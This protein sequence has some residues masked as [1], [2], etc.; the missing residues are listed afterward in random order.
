MSQTTTIRCSRL[1]Y[2]LAFLYKCCIS[3]LVIVNSCVG[4]LDVFSRN[5]LECRFLSNKHSMRLRSMRLRSAIGQSGKLIDFPDTPT[6]PLAT[7]VL[8][9]FL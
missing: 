6:Y 3:L 8:L 4:L 2:G 5:I 7:K 1:N 9:L